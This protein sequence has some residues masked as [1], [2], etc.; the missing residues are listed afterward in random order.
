[1]R[2]QLTFV[3]IIRLDTS[4]NVTIIIIRLDTSDTRFETCYLGLFAFQI[5]Q[6]LLFPRLAESVNV[7]ILELE[8]YLL[9]TEKW[10]CH[11][12]H[13]GHSQGHTTT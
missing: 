2:P 8:L 7:H 13:S 1:M 3:T 11:R 4:D 6:D 5:L 9:P 10:H 12:V